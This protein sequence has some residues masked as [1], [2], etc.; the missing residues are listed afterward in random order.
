MTLVGADSISVIHPKQNLEYNVRGFCILQVR[1]M[2]GFNLVD[3]DP[4][5]LI[6]VITRYFANN[7]E[8]GKI[9]YYGFKRLSPGEVAIDT[10]LYMFVPVISE[11]SCEV[12]KD[13]YN[14]SEN[15]KSLLLAPAVRYGNNYYVQRT[16]SIHPIEMEYLL[17]GKLKPSDTFPQTQP[18]CIYERKDYEKYFVML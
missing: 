13:H 2:N 9:C 10:A 16:R 5:K 3:A 14:V 1:F 8:I 15:S 18:I 7:Q 12:K 11:D 17:F 6:D 4:K